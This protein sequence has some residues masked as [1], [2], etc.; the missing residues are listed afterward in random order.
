MNVDKIL[1]IFKLSEK[2]ESSLQRNLPKY[3][4]NLLIL[5]FIIKNT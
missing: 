1:N 4:A 2:E 3:E 5:E